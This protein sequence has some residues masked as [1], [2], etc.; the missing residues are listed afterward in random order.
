M[1]SVLIVG[2]SEDKGIGDKGIGDEDEGM[3]VWGQ[4]GKKVRAL[5]SVPLKVFAELS[6]RS[7]NSADTLSGR[8]WPFDASSGPTTIVWWTHGGTTLPTH[9]Y[10]Y[11]RLKCGV[12]DSRHSNT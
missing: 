5:A 8:T 9:Q 6:G 3:M 12:A 11:G 10:P 4:E 7:P 2:S 1:E